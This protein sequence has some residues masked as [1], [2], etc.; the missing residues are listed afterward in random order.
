MPFCLISPQST[1]KRLLF[2]TVK[3][4]LQFINCLILEKLESCEK[5]PS[6][7]NLTPLK[8]FLCPS[9]R[10]KSKEIQF[11]YIKTEKFEIL[12]FERLETAIID[13]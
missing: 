1:F 12:A 11:N 3:E 8:Y 6:N 13:L 4:L 2:E 5:C 7:P 9:N 10:Q